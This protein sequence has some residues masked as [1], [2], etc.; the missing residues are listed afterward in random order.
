MEGEANALVRVI[1]NMCVTAL[2]DVGR[3]AEYDD[4]IN[5]Y[6]QSI[7]DKSVSLE[8]IAQGIL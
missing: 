5:F 8:T 4:V 2:A 6:G 1:N 7:H 3:V